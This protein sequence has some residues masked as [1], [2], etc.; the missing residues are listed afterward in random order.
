MKLEQL[1][2][3]TGVLCLAT[4]CSNEDDGL[5]VEIRLGASITQTRSLNMDEHSRFIKDGHEVGITIDGASMEHVNVPWLSDGQG[6]LSHISAP[7]Y[8]T[9]K[10]AAHIYAYHP[11]NAEWTDV[12][13]TSYTFSV[14]TDQSGD[15]YTQSDLLWSTATRPADYNMVVLNFAH[16]LAKIIVKLT[17]SDI[18]DLTGARFYICN[19][20]TSVG[21]QG[22]SLG[23]LGETQHE[24]FVGEMDATGKACAV[25]VPQEMKM[26]QLFM[27]VVIGEKV[28]AYRMP[29]DKEFKSGY[30][31]NYNLDVTNREATLGSTTSIPGFAQ[32][33]E[34]K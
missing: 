32:E 33:T 3:L 29:E 18:S 16:K 12:M 19:T 20:Y 21:F 11:Y 13:N 22:G 4:S 8:Y 5:P 9:G 28:Y 1:L 17:S 7:V 30:S 10:K 25:I 6:N 2:L 15:G 34:W 24:I 31:Y 27:R 26:N 23:D 14:A